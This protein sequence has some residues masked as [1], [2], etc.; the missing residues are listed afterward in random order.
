MKT[1]ARP[2]A[3]PANTRPAAR[4]A[5]LSPTAKITLPITESTQQA[6]IPART[7]ILRASAAPARLPTAEPAKKKVPESRPTSPRVMSKSF[8]SE[9]T[10]GPT[11]PQFHPVIARARTK[12]PMLRRALTAGFY[13]TARMGC[14]P[15]EADS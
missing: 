3:T 6:Q 14:R 13:R 8:V 4:T 5:K 1:A 12:T 9:S 2:K 10:T 7:R 15:V 11:L